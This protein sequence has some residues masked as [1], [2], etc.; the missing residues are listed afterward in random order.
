MSRAPKGQPEE[1]PQ[2]RL[3]VLKFDGDFQQGFRVLLE[4]GNEARRPLIELSGSLPPNPQLALQLSKWQQHYHSLSA[5]SLINSRI[6]PQSIV[7]GGSINRLEDCWQSATRLHRL[8]TEWLESPAFRRLD[9]RIRENLSLNDSIRVLIRTQDPLLRRLPWHLWDFVDR[10][11]K[12]EVALSAPFFEQALV[13]PEPHGAQVN[14]LAVLG[15]SK[16]INVQADRQFLSELP[17]AQVTF[18]IEPSREEISQQLWRQPWDILFFAGHSS[19]E[20][21]RGLVYI[22]GDEV[23]TLEELRYGIKQAIANGL[24]LAIFNSCNGLGLAQ[25]L[26]S[27]H[28]PQMVVMREPVPDYVAQTFLK[29]LLKAYSSGKS[30]YLAVREAREQLQSIED[31]F[32]CATWLPIICQNSAR[33]PPTWHSLTHPSINSAAQTRSDTKAENTKAERKPSRAKQHAFAPIKRIFDLN[34]WLPLFARQTYRKG[35]VALLIVALVTVGLTMP[36]VTGWAQPYEMAMYDHYMRSRPD[37]GEDARLLIVEITDADI[38]AQ[39]ANGEEL[40]RRS[41]SAQ[42]YGQIFDTSLSDRSLHRLLVTLEQYNP[43]V[44]GLDIYRD[45][46]AAPNQTELVTHLRD[47]SNL[48]AVCKA[49][50]F[51][52]SS[53]PSID[54]PP[55]VPL[56]RV[57]FSDFREDSDGTLRRHLLGMLPIVRTQDS[58]CNTNASFSLQIA[59]QYLHQQAVDTQFTEVGD[60]SLDHQ[61]VEVL[62]SHSSAYPPDPGGREIMLNY[63]ATDEIAPHVTLQQILNEQVN[64]DYIKDK[65]VLIGVTASGGEDTWFTPRDPSAAMPGVFVQAHMVSQIISAAL[66]RRPL[67]S[68]LSSWQRLG[69]FSIWA[70]VGAFLGLWSS[71]KKPLS[72]GLLRLAVSLA[73]A[74]LILYGICFI[75]LI[76]GCWLPFASILLSLI[77]A[78]TLTTIYLIASQR[79]NL[80]T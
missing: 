55:E 69:W 47:S 75:S 72:S 71:R 11:A 7:Y 53:I 3:V 14:I 67:L 48:V 21:D 33:I 29:S 23:L 2:E 27:L 31:K 32:P 4:I 59:S 39:K 45:F 61:A 1:Q 16:N 50:D 74:T 62:H 63:R 37:E 73:A 41:L 19:T 51:E 57:G 60:L 44:I 24:Q 40:K 38:E 22:G 28:L 65:I 77:A 30:L 56:S 13:A 80:R 78:S 8:M 18:L 68:P 26:E 49:E 46:A 42:S 34:R 64:P 10:Y 9:L 43:R 17:N 36:A 76:R 12:A 58:R 35:W 66:D 25:S 5:N 6:Q 79:R 52:D 20:G 15:N 54:P 70:S